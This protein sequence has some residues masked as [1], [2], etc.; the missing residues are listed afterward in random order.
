MGQSP[1]SP[2]NRLSSAAYLESAKWMEKISQK[3][4]GFDLIS[5]A[6]AYCFGHHPLA[7]DIAGLITTSN[8][9]LLHVIAGDALATQSLRPKF[10]AAGVSLE[11]VVKA[12]HLSLDFERV[13]TPTSGPNKALANFTMGRCFLLND[14][15]PIVARRWP[16]E[17]NLEA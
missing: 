8:R 15:F 4:V 6:P 17:V 10:L 12:V 11:D 2:L 7:A 3:G 16:E 5:L 9:V 14:A 1:T 13:K